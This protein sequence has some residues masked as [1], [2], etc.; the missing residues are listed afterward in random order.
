M[1]KQNLA[2]FVRRIRAGDEQAAADLVRQCE[3]LVRREIRLRLTDPRLCRAL[4]SMDIC[5]SVMASF[6]VQAACGRYELDEPGQLIKLLVGMARN[7]LASATRKQ[8]AQR[9]DTRRVVPTAVDEVDPAGGVATPSRIVAGKELLREVQQRLSEEE[10]ELAQRRA[11][12]Q[13]WEEIAAELGG[14]PDGRRVQFARALDRV[15]QQLGL[16]Q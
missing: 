12:G 7:K 14:T 9:R 1:S 11:Q 13:R 15:T 4:D 8:R 6:F 3:P 10:R 2:D 5:Q 16:D